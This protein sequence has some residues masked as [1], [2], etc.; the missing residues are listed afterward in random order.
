MAEGNVE[1]V[2]GIY[3]RWGR[4]DFSAGTD[5]YDPYVQLVLRP[6]FPEAGTYSGPEEIRRYMQ[7]DFLAD[8]AGAAIAGEEFIAAGDSV[9]VHVHQSA[10]GPESGAP[11]SMRYYQVWSFRG[12]SVI[13]IESIRE[14]ADALEAVGIR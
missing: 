7:E 12:D 1:V 6:E 4:G 3:E 5:L 8:F 10:T 11:V 9:V 14:R 13:R 2:R